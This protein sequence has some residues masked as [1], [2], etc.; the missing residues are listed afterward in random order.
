ML[1]KTTSLENWRA[2]INLSRPFLLIPVTTSS[3]AQFCY[4][5]YRYIH[6]IQL[7]DPEAGELKIDGKAYK[8]K[9]IH[10][11]SPSEHTF[12]GTVYPLELHVVHK[13]KDGTSAVLAV[14]YDYG[15]KEDGLI[16]KIKDELAELAKDK[17]SPEEESQVPIKKIE[18]KML[19]GRA[20]K[21]YRYE[22]SLTFPPCT[23]QVSWNVIAK[24]LKG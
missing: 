9:Q 20:P 10:W 8:L 14:L 17:C 3:Y 7:E 23:E 11:H 6:F 24:I 12:N 18:F 21:Y 4:V 22:G 13:A 19:K 15:E 1:L 16:K 5:T 2:N